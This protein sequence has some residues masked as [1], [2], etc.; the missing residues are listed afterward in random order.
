MGSLA[1]F[2]DLTAASSRAEPCCGPS[3]WRSAHPAAGNFAACPTAKRRCNRAASN[4]VTCSLRQHDIKPGASQLVALQQSPVA[5]LS[6]VVLCSFQRL[7]PLQARLLTLIMACSFT[8]PQTCEQNI[9]PHGGSQQGAHG[10]GH[11]AAFEGIARLQA[12]EYS[13]KFI[14]RTCL[15][16]AVAVQHCHTSA[17]ESIARLVVEAEH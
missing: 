5:V 11:N 4:L 8:S 16:F 14:L 2:L 1:S 10:R 15:L 13:L 6:V 9:S 12:L 3:D 7:L 17:L